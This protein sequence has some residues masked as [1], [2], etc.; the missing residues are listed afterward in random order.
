MNKIF[1]DS[2]WNLTSQVIPTFAALFSIPLI[3]KTGGIEIFGVITLVWALVNFTGVLDFGISKVLTKEISEN[4]DN[5][6]K[7]KIISFVGIFMITLLGILI[8]LLIYFSQDLIINSI[9]F[10]SSFNKTETL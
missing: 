6:K 3:I 10:D 8:S 4:A 7:L 1:R 5:L 2:A 9:F